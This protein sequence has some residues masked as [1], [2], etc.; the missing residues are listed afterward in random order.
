MSKSDDVRLYG[1]VEEFRQ[2]ARNAKEPVADARVRASFDTE[3]KA[4]EGDSRTLMFTISSAS[5][6]RMGDSIAVSGW[7][8]DAYRK[9]PVVLWA[10][11]ATLL[12]L[13]KAPKVW[14]EGEKLKADAEFTPI[15]MA[16]F[17]DTVFDMYKQGF[18]S[19]TSVGFIPLKY[20]FT[21]DPQRRYGIDFLEQELLE[22]SCV[23]I[24]ANSDALIEGRAAGI[25]IL[26]VLDWAE[27]QIK[28]CG[29][30]ARIIKLA[31]GVLGSNGEDLVAI[32]WA[33][34]II[35]AAGKK[36]AGRDEAVVSTQ[37]LE[38]IERAAKNKRLAEKRARELDA[39]RIR[40]V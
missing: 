8:M 20:A 18:L 37:R 3:V 6:D 26:P 35:T 31:E 4:G 13:A 7:K 23:P 21:D 16:R 34:R 25:D 15:G 19:A 1:S 33:E 27:D 5:V 38:A 30:N 11:D 32:S 12:P 24:P 29:D 2:A 14:V 17:N 40:S 9:N 22:F 10:H 39:I 28:R 36:I